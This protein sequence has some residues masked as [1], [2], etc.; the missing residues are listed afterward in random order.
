MRKIKKKTENTFISKKAKQNK[1]KSKNIKLK[2]NNKV[3]KYL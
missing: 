2:V 3:E 1:T